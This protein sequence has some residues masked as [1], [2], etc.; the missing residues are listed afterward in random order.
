[1]PPASA[2]ALQLAAVSPEAQSV[3]LRDGFDVVAAAD[4]ATIDP[5]HS[6]VRLRLDGHAVATRGLRVTPDFVSYTPEG[7]LAEGSHS[8]HVEVLGADGRSSS[9]EWNFYVVGS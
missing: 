9:V 4:G 5:T 2:P 7:T 1:V 8:V 6:T 3:V